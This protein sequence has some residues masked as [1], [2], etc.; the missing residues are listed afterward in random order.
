[1]ADLLISYQKRNLSALCFLDL[2]VEIRQKV[3]RHYF[4]CPQGF[5]IHLIDCYRSGAS[6]AFKSPGVVISTVY[7]G[8]LPP[9]LHQP[10]NKVS[11]VHG[12]A[13]SDRLGRKFWSLLLVNKGILSEVLPR[14]EAISNFSVYD[15]QPAS[16]P[17]ALTRQNHRRYHRR[18][19]IVPTDVQRNIKHL[20]ISRNI[21]D[22]CN[23]FSPRL[24]EWSTQPGWQSI[25]HSMTKLQTL[26]VTGVGGYDLQTFLHTWS[27]PNVI[28]LNGD[29][30][31]QML[32]YTNRDE[33]DED[34]NGQF[35]DS[36]H[37]ET[38]Y[39]LDPPRLILPPLKCLALECLMSEGAL[40]ELEHEDFRGLR[41]A[42]VEAEPG[43]HRGV[44]KLIK[45][46]VA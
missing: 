29:I 12:D 22:I 39:A 3:Y 25:L 35:P 13:T 24:A 44:Y 14:M 8:E 32:I 16:D 9:E 23:T 4:Y 34:V 11:Q 1:M 42:K 33:E 6:I 43:S 18:L 10:K 26:T 41:L 2:P 38:W 36:N 27:R 45:A 5:T 30:E 40:D 28:F 17:G 19:D 46:T 20:K 7:D 37:P 31:L 21:L 15:A